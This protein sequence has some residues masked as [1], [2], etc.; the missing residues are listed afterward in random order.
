[1]HIQVSGALFTAFLS[2]ER[3]RT[4]MK[5]ELFLARFTRD[6]QLSVEWGE[7]H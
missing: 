1:M 3:G 6:L 4:C 2:L 7:K 5:K